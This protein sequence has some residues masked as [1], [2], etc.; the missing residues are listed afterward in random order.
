M[1]PEDIKTLKVILATFKFDVAEIV[2]E[3]VRE[4]LNENQKPKKYVEVGYRG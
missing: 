2:E 1:T 3:K 4:I